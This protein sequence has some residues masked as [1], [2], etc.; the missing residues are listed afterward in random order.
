MEPVIEKQ[1]LLEQYKD[2]FSDEHL[3][4]I[5]NTELT[6]DARIPQVITGD[7]AEARIINGHYLVNYLGPNPGAKRLE[8]QKLF[9]A[10]KAAAIEAKAALIQAVEDAKAS[11]APAIEEPNK[12]KAGKKADTPV[13][14]TVN[15]PEVTQ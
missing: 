12:G 10:K 2:K 3:F 11:E 5:V 4:E 8:A 1:K 9:A 15:L 7:Q 13:E 14:T 6:E